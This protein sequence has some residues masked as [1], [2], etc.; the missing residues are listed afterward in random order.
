V[1][2]SNIVELLVKGHDMD[3]LKW[4]L[5]ASLLVAMMFLGLKAEPSKSNNDKKN[6]VT[7]IF[8]LL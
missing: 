7:S 6:A 4:L 3:M 8:K 2:T 1:Y 5:K